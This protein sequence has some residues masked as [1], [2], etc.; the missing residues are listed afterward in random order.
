[1]ESERRTLSERL[2]RAQAEIDALQRKVEDVSKRASEADRYANELGLRDGQLTQVGSDLARLTQEL[3]ET[4]AARHRSERALE[5]LTTQA[6]TLEQQLH[7]AQRELAEAQSTRDALSGERETLLPLRDALEQRVREVEALNAELAQMRTSRTALQEQVTE[8]AP[9]REQLDDRNA[10]LQSASDLMTAMR[11]QL[12][13][14]QTQVDTL[15]RAAVAQRQELA[16]AQQALVDL[17]SHRDEVQRSLE[18]ALRNNERLQAVSK[19]DTDL[20]NERNAQLTSLRQEIEKRAEE[21]RG[22]EHSLSARDQLIEDLRT[23]IRTVQ[24]ERAIVAEQ[25]AK[26]RTRVKGLTQ[27][28]FDRDNRI[29]VLKSDL[30]VHTEALAAI[31]RDVDRIE[32]PATVAEPSAERILE[33]LN[34]EGDPIV[35]NRRVMTIGRTNDN[36][37]FI[38]SKMISRHHA[39]LLIGPNAVIVEDAGSTN[40][41]FVN[42]QQV[43]QHVLREGDVLTIGDLKFR[44]S[45]RG[46]VDA[47]PRDNVVEFEP[48]G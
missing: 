1:L 30:A 17:H 24:D 19:D 44:L 13:E 4:S 29:A 32:S 35:L 11:T 33:P 22:F 7:Q 48:K 10:A 21:I 34:H 43:K 25:L 47:R 5:E 28:I 23:E 8:L 36:D 3:Q 41:C 14:M 18:E 20:L 9:L 39:R 42:E 38:P 40:G 12:A 2:E 16:I 26:S 37:I 27:K 46:N 31:R 6:A 45:M 15:T